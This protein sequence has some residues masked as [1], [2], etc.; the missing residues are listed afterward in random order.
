MLETTILGPNGTTSQL[1]K[2]KKKTSIGAKTK[3]IRFALKGKINSFKN[4]LT[5]SAIACNKPKGPT[6]FG[7][8]R[9]CIEAKNFRSYTVKNATVINIHKIIIKKRT[10]E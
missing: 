6:T 5:P 2:L 4:N 9:W 7:P 10:N 8:T 1:I 3:R